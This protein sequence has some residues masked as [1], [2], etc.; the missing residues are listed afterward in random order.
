VHGTNNTA[1]FTCRLSKILETSTSWSPVIVKK[2]DALDENNMILK[3]LPGG[4]EEY[5]KVLY[6]HYYP[7]KLKRDLF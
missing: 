7:L 4:V 3:L 5:K 6:C 2:R 1:T